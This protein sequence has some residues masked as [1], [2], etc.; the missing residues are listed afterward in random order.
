MGMLT[1]P[2][3]VLVNSLKLTA[4]AV[5]MLILTRRRLGGMGNHRL[6]TLTLKATGSSLVMAAVT[7]SVMHAIAAAAP[8]GLM[9]NVLVVG[10]AGGAGAVVYALLALALHLEGIQ[11]IHAAF[12]EGWHRLTGTER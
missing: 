4:H 5:T 10:A 12:V 11:L 3:L 9:G 1:L 6:W 7:S 8:P 2:L